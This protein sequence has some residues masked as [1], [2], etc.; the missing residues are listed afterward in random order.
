M[1]R[2]YPALIADRQHFAEAAY[3][4][5]EWRCILGDSGQ[6]VN[7]ER[8]EPA[9]QKALTNT[10]IRP[11]GQWCTLFDKPHHIRLRADTW[12]AQHNPPVEWTPDRVF[13]HAVVNGT[14]SPL[15]TACKTRNVVVV[16]PAHIARLPESV[17]GPVTH[18]RIP[19][20]TAW[21]AVEQTCDTLLDTLNPDDL[22]LFCAGMAA[23]LMIHRLWPLVC[24]V[25]LYDVGAALDPFCGVYSR[26]IYREAAW[27]KDIMPRNLA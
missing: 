9:L 8:Y 17:I 18:V 2:D 16:G 6:N 7:G 20:A 15:F 14:A 21:K 3:R 23:N 26:R 4:D 27:Q 22:V 11:V 25:T 13:L 1:V 5:G 12:I 19:E 24:D 10:L